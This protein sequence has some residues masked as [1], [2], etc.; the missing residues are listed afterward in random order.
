M[1]IS[2]TDTLNMKARLMGRVF[3]LVAV[4][5]A[6]FS[7]GLW[8]QEEVLSEPK[9]AG[10]RGTLVYSLQFSPKGEADIAGMLPDTLRIFVGEHAIRMQ[11]DGENFPPEAR[12]EVQVDTRTGLVQLIYP[13]GQTVF[14]LPE[15]KEEDKG[16]VTR[17][18]ETMTL[19]EQKARKYMV[20][21]VEAKT[22][23]TAWIGEELF[24]P[25]DQTVRLQTGLPVLS[26]ST[27]LD[28]CLKMTNQNPHGT[29]TIQLES[30][31]P[32]EL[33]E[34][35]FLIP[36]DYEQKPFDEYLQRLSILKE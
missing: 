7:S 30:I 25:V 28:F 11:F 2:E 14:S 16:K 9:P 22:T 29:Q 19:L 35:T 26:D 24:L 15:M 27:R 17:T 1:W 12:E 34:A 10:F 3:T 33:P 20:R 8:A 21:Y 31:Q 6:L 13:S 18:G 36:G 23:Q 5:C 4:L 32:E